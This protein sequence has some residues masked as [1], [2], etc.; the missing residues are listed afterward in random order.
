M[1]EQSPAAPA[2]ILGFWR[3]LEVFNIPTAPTPK[4][5][6]KQVKIVTVRPGETLPWKRR[7]FTPTDE[8]GFIHVVYLGTADMEDMS[9]LLLQS[10]FPDQ[11]LSERERQRASGRGWLAAFV[12]N[13]YGCAKLDSYLA[14][15]FAHGAMALRETNSVANV[16]AR[17]QRATG[18]FTERRHKLELAP[19]EAPPTI[20]ASSLSWQDLDE[21]LAV[22]R[23]LLGP[24]ADDPSIDWRLVV[25]VSR[26]KRR[27]VDDNLQA[28]TEFLNSFYLDDLDRLIAQTGG[29]QPFGKALAS[30]LGPEVP[31]PLRVDVLADHVAMTQLVSAKHLPSARWPT[32]SAEPLVLAQQA[33][34]AHVLRTLRGHPGVVGV[35]GPPGT[36]KT[37]LLRDVIAEVIV[38]RA[39]RIAAL[40]KPGEI[41]EPEATS[42]DGKKFTPIKTDIMAGTAIV[43]ASNNNNA[44][45]NITQELP[46]RARISP[47]FGEPTYFDE[48]IR[49]VFAAQHVVDE[50]KQP[51]ETWGLIAAALGNVGNRRAFAKG[52]YRGETK[53]AAEDIDDIAPESESVDNVEAIGQE[54]GQAEPPSIKQVLDQADAEYARYISEWRTAKQRFTDLL[55]QFDTVRS[56]LIAAEQAAAKIGEHQRQLTVHEA[57]LAEKAAH[58][59][60]IVNRLAQSQQARQDQRTLV[61]SRTAS[62]AS[63]R[64]QH[65]PSLIE[66]MLAWIGVRTTSLEEKHQRIASATQSLAEAS[67]ALATMSRDILVAE[68]QLREQERQ[69]GEQRRQTDALKAEIR[70]HQLVLDKGYATGA[71]H[72]PDG[73]FWQMPNGDRHR[74]SIAVGP[75]ID[76]LRALIFLEAVELHRLTILTNTGKFAGN[77]RAVNGMLTGSSRDRVPLSQRPML[78]D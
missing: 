47:E 28:A 6:T 38:E 25:R 67:E 22:V 9:R 15:S 55:A 19:G 12:V 73:Q 35:N 64:Q 31:K 57:A 33:T 68:Q 74:A 63:I 27:Y 54:Q 48:V 7:E 30:Y 61:E 14:A 60:T 29:N 40:A 8:Y 1:A 36:G 50:D 76:K 26:V 23:K 5:N 49:E 51:I 62:L 56:T 18:E 45:K 78:W 34:V 32:S 53:K 24:H 39:R 37:T 52:F 42:V 3:D 71:K 46:A 77:L 11:D 44:V 65:A 72:F 2:S 17:L 10:V 75:A 16:N 66:R 13:E 21:E 58:V 70:R 69:L 59:A 4:D 20:A 43:V 41:F